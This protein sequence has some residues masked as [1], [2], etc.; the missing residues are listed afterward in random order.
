MGCDN[1][2]QKRE[3]RGGSISIRAPL[4]GVRLSGSFAHAAASTFQSAHPYV[5]CDNHDNVATLPNVRI[6]I[7]APLCGVRLPM[8]SVLNGIFNFNPRT[9]MWGATAHLGALL[10]C[11]NISIR[12][13]L[14]GVRLKTYY[15]PPKAPTFQSA[16]PYVGCDVDKDRNDI[17]DQSISIRAPLCG[18][19]PLNS[20]ILSTGQEISIRA[21]LC[22]VRPGAGNLA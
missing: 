6:S 10:I 19:R 15:L 22:G 14:C 11:G 1:H 18:V 12:A 8:S 21:P 2:R 16:H 3:H 9:P 5:G 13:P 20:T 17:V 7:R 4:C